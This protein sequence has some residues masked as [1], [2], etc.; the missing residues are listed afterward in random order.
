VYV[1]PPVTVVPA[2]PPVYVERDE[3]AAQ[4]APLESGFWYY[5]R[6]PA[7]YYP[8]VRECPGGWEKVPPRPPGAQ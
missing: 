8:T 1:Y 5:C 7:G 6:S 2:Q 4:S 3:P